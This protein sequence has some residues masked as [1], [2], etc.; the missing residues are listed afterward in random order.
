MTTLRRTWNFADGL[1][2][3]VLTLVAIWVSRDV[4]SDML[5][6]GWRDAENSHLLLA[7][8]V[9]AWLVWVR[10]ERLRFARPQVS[11]VG[12]LLVA[13]GWAAA[14]L[15][16]MN[17]VMIAEHGGALLIVMGAA[18]TMLGTH[19]VRLFLPAAL[20][21]CFVLPV[22]GR[23]RQAVAIPLQEAT[24]AVT[25]YLLDILSVPVE[26][27]GNV[28]SING[29]EVA[30]AEACN[31]MRMV[32]ALLLITFA[33]VFSVPM[34]H[35]VRVLFLLVSPLIALLVNV[36]RLVPTV[37]SY[38]YGSIGF[39]DAFHQASGWIMLFVALGILWLTFCL[40][41]WLEIP[42][43]PHPVGIEE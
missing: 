17:E 2:L 24:A 43:S 5:A 4:W 34:R 3:G 28:L 33:F 11:L 7:P 19:V 39:A 13:V 21:L 6:I 27:L 1:W 32:T 23:I 26:R 9:A 42:V 15:G 14:R 37:L 35:S 8:F 20:A 38:G 10:R 22:P 12:P 29:Q 40:L 18:V 25:H 36:I 31:G 41:R 16:Y 30:V